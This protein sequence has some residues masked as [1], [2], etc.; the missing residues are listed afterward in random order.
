MLIGAAAAGEGARVYEAA[1]LKTLGASR[2]TILGSFA[3][4]SGLMGAA[5]GLVALAAGCLGAWAVVTFVMEST[6]RVAWGNALGVVLAGCWPR[7][8]RGSPLPGGLWRRGRR[9][10]SGPGS[11]AGGMHAPGPP[12]AGLR[13][14]PAPRAS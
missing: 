8:W 11:K 3:L 12:R 1:V 9:R 6:Y 2:A 10:C 13:L 7:C 5:A 4:R 14:Y